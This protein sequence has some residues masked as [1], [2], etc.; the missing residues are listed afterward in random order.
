MRHAAT[1]ILPEFRSGIEL[2]RE[3]FSGIFVVFSTDFNSKLVTWSVKA[4]WDC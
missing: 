2:S 4:F 3:V 1:V